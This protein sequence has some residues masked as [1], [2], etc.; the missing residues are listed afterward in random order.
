MV[1]VLRELLLGLR[2]ALQLGI[3]VRADIVGRAAGARVFCGIFVGSISWSFYWW[4][5]GRL[6]LW[7]ECGGGW[8]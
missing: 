6:V 1:V 8:L 7:W 3:L 4:D 5:V 2:W